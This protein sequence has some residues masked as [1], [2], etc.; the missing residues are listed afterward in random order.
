M[1]VLELK[2][3]QSNVEVEGEIKEIGEIREF[4]SYGR[5]LRVATAK[6][7]DDSGSIEFNSYGRQLRVATAKIQ[8]DSGS[9]DLS[10]WNE[11]IDKVKVGD[12]VKITNGYVKDFQGALQLTAGKFGKIEVIRESD[13]EKQKK[14][15]KLMKLKSLEKKLW[16]NKRRNFSK[17]FLFFLFCRNSFCK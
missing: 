10:L 11:D 5:Q 3:G 6:I 8:D 7:Q 4:N 1:K 13:E 17:L 15:K 16:K 14:L 9:I 2:S 12:K